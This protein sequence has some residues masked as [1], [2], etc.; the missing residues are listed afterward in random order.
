M[1]PVGFESTV[2]ARERPQ[3]YFLDYATTGNDVRLF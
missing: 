3:T 1:L 2:S